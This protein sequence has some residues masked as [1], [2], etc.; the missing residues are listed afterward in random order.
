[1]LGHELGQV[2]DFSFCP[3]FGDQIQVALHLF[4]YNNINYKVFASCARFEK[5]HANSISRDFHDNILGV[6]MCFNVDNQSLILMATSLKKKIRR[7]NM[8]SLIL[9]KGTKTRVLL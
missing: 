2:K 9:I 4:N 7:C 5:F 8:T 1:V 6:S 3:F